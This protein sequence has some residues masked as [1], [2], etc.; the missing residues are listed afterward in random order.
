MLFQSY[1]ELQRLFSVDEH[2]ALLEKKNTDR[3]PE[4][5]YDRSKLADMDNSEC[6]ANFTSKT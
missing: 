2:I 3:N 4:F 5:D 1:L 6:K